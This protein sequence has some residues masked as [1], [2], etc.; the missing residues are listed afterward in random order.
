M[1]RFF[2]I[3]GVICELNPPHNGHFSLFEQIKQNDH[4]AVIAVLSGNFVQRGQPAIFDKW[5]RAKTAL[6]C[7]ADLVIELPLPW[8]VSGAEQFAQGGVG[9]LHAL[10]CVDTLYFGSEC[11]RIDPLQTIADTLSSAAFQSTFQREREKNPSANFASVR[12]SAIASLLGDTTASILNA[13]NNN[14]GIAYCQAIRQLESSIRP[15]TIPRTGA[16]YHDSG[17][18]HT[19]Q[20][21]SATQ[22]RTLLQKNPACDLSPFVPKNCGEILN[23]AIAKGFGPVFPEQMELAVLT[24][25]RTLSLSQLEQLPDLSEGLERR[26]YQAIRKATSLRE[27]YDLAK[28]KRYSHARIRRLVLA[29]FLGITASH[30]AALPPYCRILAMNATGAKILSICKETATIP[31]LM[32]YADSKH[33]SEPAKELFSLECQATDLFSLFCPTPQPCGLDMTTPIISQN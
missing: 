21:P 5:T 4:A 22:L 17:L 30:G 25:L 13:P 32:K 1:S 6:A 9:L 28:T 11:G 10:S 14:L 27:L 24:K 16:A 20:F 8:A 7:G 26:L 2:Q 33:L 29:A 31:F 23:N 3:S 19:N 18:P 15:V 12:Q